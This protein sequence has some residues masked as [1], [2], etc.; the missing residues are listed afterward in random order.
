VPDIYVYGSKNG[1]SVLSGTTTTKARYVRHYFNADGTQNSVTESSP[2]IVKSGKYSPIS[3]SL[4]GVAF[5][6]AI[7]TINTVEKGTIKGQFY[8]G[9]I[10]NTARKDMVVWGYFYADPKEVAWGDKNNPEVFIKIWLDQPTGRYDVNFFH[11]SV[12]NI[13][14]TSLIEYVNDSKILDYDTTTFIESTVT[15]SQRY[16]R[17]EYT[18]K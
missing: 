1:K 12:P 11:V 15:L 18:L 13:S 14:V 17:H 7:V 3:S 6:D 10:G 2:E 4:G 9:G 8:A 16:A 5:A